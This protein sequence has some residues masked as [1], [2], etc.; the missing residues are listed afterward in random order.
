M[1]V[2]VPFRN[3]V[4]VRPIFRPSPLPFQSMPLPA[5]LHLASDTPLAPYLSFQSFPPILSPWLR[6]MSSAGWGL[7]SL[8]QMGLGCPLLT[9][10]ECSA[11]PSCPSQASPHQGLPMVGQSRLQVVISRYNLMWLIASFTFIT[12]I[13]L[14]SC[15]RTRKTSLSDSAFIHTVRSKLKTSISSHFCSCRSVKAIYSFNLFPVWLG[16]KF[17][18]K[19]LLVWK[20]TSCQIEYM[21]WF[22]CLFVRMFF[23]ISGNPSPVLVLHSHLLFFY[24]SREGRK[25]GNADL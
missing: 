17:P 8:L 11:D 24:R 18:A 4:H 23:P 9:S 3:T 7:C 5:A 16:R 14:S 15:C 6:W 25:E 21:G 20:R 12:H 22:F 13:S 1:R 19:T 2:N 10:A